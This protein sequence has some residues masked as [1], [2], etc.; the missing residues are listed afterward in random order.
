LNV[1]LPKYILR[2][3]S[4]GGTKAGDKSGSDDRNETVRKEVMTRSESVE[5]I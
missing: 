4:D 1:R 2:D 3:C 5:R